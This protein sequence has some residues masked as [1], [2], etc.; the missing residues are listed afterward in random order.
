MRGDAVRASRFANKR[1]LN[2]IRL[3]AITPDIARLPQRRH[4]VNV[5][6]QLE[7]GYFALTAGKGMDAALCGPLA[8]CVSMKSSS[9]ERPRSDRRTNVNSLGFVSDTSVIVLP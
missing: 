9:E 8:H 3:P 5:H 7:H 6:A 2:R 1:R 4:V